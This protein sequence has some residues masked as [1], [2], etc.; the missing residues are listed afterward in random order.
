M[1]QYVQEQN[2]NQTESSKTE[3]ER[4]TYSLSSTSTTRTRA[5]ARED[6]QIFE[7]E[8]RR[9]LGQLTPVITRQLI[10]YLRDGM[11]VD[12][13]RH[14]L[15]QTEMAPRPSKNYFMAILRRYYTAEIRTM[16]DVHADEDRFRQGWAGSRGW[17]NPALDYAQRPVSNYD[18]FEFTDLSQYVDECE[19]AST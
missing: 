5:R 11:A 14:A 6:V 13:M 1:T 15:E 8:Y 19:A 16:D 12:V 10:G 2:L 17:K 18:D 9:L 4:V 7:E 3:S